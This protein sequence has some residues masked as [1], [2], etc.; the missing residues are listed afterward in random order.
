MPITRDEVEHVALLARLELTDQERESFTR[1]LD[2]ILTFFDTLR[3]A[4]TTDIKPTAH[5][6]DLDTPFR[7]D[8]VTNAPDTDAYLANAAQR[9]GNLFKVPKI[10]E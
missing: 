4:D 3:E 5:V 8:L 2:Q 10:I 1:Q 7:D 9:D 6:A